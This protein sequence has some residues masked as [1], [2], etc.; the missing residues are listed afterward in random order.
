[1]KIRGWGA[2]YEFGRQRVGQ[3]LQYHLLG[4]QVPG[5][6]RPGYRVEPK[7]TRLT[8]I[9]ASVLK[10]RPDRPQWSWMTIRF[11]LRLRRGRLERLAE[12][13]AR[14]GTG[15]PGQAVAQPDTRSLG[16]EDQI[17]RAAAQWRR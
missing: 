5:R 13:R 17:G 12:G 3:I 2:I 16:D 4:Q 8:D 6:C 11:H 9:G 15:Q 1:M 10:G 7:A 14:V